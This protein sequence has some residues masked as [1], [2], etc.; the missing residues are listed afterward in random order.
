MAAKI[1][2]YYL[3]ICILFQAL[4]LL[5]D[6]AFEAQCLGLCRESKEAKLRGVVDVECTL[7]K[8]GSEYISSSD[9]FYIP[10]KR[11]KTNAYNIGPVCYGP[12][13]YDSPTSNKVSSKANMFPTTPGLNKKLV[14]SPTSDSNK[15][16]SKANMFPTT[17]GSNKKLVDSP[18]RNPRN[19]FSESSYGKYLQVL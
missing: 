6:P 19:F 13:T 1:Y 14:D 4:L 7:N 15:V 12:C 16:S 11:S 9:D 3:I 18:T 17:P 5:R 2:N 10:K 8:R